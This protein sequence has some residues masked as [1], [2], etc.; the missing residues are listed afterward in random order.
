METVKVDTGIAPVE[1]FKIDEDIEN[2]YADLFGY[3]EGDN[4]PEETPVELKDIPSL[5]GVANEM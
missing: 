3:L 4:E 1:T 2:E 5:F